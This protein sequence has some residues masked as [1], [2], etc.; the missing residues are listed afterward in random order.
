[1]FE[2][3]KG[4]TIAGELTG[5]N[6]SN[7]EVDKAWR[8]SGKY[9]IKGLSLNYE[10]LQAGE[11]FRGGYQDIKSRRFDGSW[12]PVHNLNLWTN[13]YTSRDNLDD[14]PDEEVFRNRD[15]TYGGAWTIDK[16]G[17]LGVTHRSAEHVDVMEW[18]L[19]EKINS[20]EYSYSTYFNNI[21]ASTVW[22][23]RTDKDRLTGDIEKNRSLQFRCVARI[24]ESASLR[25][26]LT[27]GR[28][29]L[30]DG[31]FTRHLTSVGLGC[32]LRLTRDV[33]LS[34]NFERNI[35]NPSGQRTGIVGSLDWD[36]SEGRKFRLHFRSLKGSFGQNT[37]MALEYDYP[38]NIPL[39][40]FPIMGRVEGRLYLLNDPDLGIPGVRVLVNGFEA[41]TDNFGN[42]RLPS[43][44]PG[45]YELNL[46]YA[47]LDIGLTP[48][49]DLPYRFALEAG[50]T[51]EIEIPMIRS[52]SIGGYVRLESPAEDGEI[53]PDEPFGGILVELQSVSGSEFRYTD[54]SG[55]F[56]F[57]DLGPGAYIL[58]IRTESLPQYFEVV[59][60]TEYSILLAPGKVRGDQDFLVKPVE[61][62]IIIVLT[63]N[64]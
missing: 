25:F 34:L 10:M 19:D 56:V 31:E 29:S 59:D 61:R 64:G 13:Y 46:D 21:Y 30:N 37:E 7:S 28:S 53:Q 12:H 3:F 14:N 57:S 50:S 1:A 17:R 26:N 52:A 44:L 35:E 16:F 15:F 8:L 60:L 43:L 39:K 20:T 22:R 62:E 24:D 2:P 58:K 45:E 41:M 27:S 49:I 18:S 55:H 42:F 36:M 23:L 11:D 38:I 32:E 6:S 5:T 40:V 63:S 9:R 54:D 4:T 47:T 33:D 51:V 48:E